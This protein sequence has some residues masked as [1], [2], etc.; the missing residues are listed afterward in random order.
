MKLSILQ[1]A[2]EEPHGLALI[3][4]EKSYRFAELE[5]LVDGR[6]S[7]LQE[8]GLREGEGVAVVARS[9]VGT[10][11][12]LYAL[13]ER[14]MPVV[15]LHPRL[16]Q[17]ERAPILA[18]VTPRL[19]VD[20]EDWTVLAG[21]ATLL[22][23]DRGE[24]MLA[25]VSTSGSSGRPKGALLSR[26]AICA[27]AEASEKNLGWQEHDRWLL[28]L[29]LAHVGGLSVVTR[30]LIARRCVVLGKS[31]SFSAESA[32]LEIEQQ[33]I[34]L[35]SLVPTQLSRLLC[36]APER[37]PPRSIRAVLLGG[38]PA[39]AALLSRAAAAGWPVL[40]S[41]G[42]TEACSQVATQPYG[43]LPGQE[44]GVGRPL[45]GVEVRIVEGRIQ[46][47]GDCLFS[48]YL[49]SGES[50][51]P[52]TPDGWFD[53]GD[54]GTWGEGGCLHVL[55]KRC[56]LIISGGEN[57]YPAEVE[58]ALEKIP[59]ICAACVF[60][61]P[62]PEWGQ[63]V[64]AALVVEEPCD[65]AQLESQMKALLAPWKRP[66]R[67]VTCPDFPSTPSGKPDRRRIIEEALVR[68]GPLSA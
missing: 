41:Y 16:G 1:A 68:I 66:R 35:L 47:K 43:T 36:F 55:S 13:F 2:R 56:D 39:P 8:I 31:G 59:G 5:A 46:V 42:L 34:T 29:S 6:I 3:S 38:A 20:G 17:G 58:Q 26:R 40:T 48:G 50:L 45:A 15:L 44:M 60:G 7:R 67:W 57:V 4:A 52:G 18:E 28:N 54:L 53:T 14:R 65:R 21:Q 61:V 49:G 23:R 25:V 11:L 27:S 51:D 10:L 63:V 30:C 19:L 62:D 24:P 12:L 22:P 37:K 33:R 32:W 9:D 64:A